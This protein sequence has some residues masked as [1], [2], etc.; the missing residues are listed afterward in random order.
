[1]RSLE[2]DS[3]LYLFLEF[4]KSYWNRLRKLLML[5]ESLR[6]ELILVGS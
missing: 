1:M 5:R 2:P 3:R 4:H 6:L